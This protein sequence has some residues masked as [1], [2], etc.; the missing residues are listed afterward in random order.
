MAR[1]EKRRRERFAELKRL[2]NG[3]LPY[4][5]REYLLSRSELGFYLA[6]KTA[7][8][9]RFMIVPKVRLADIVNCSDADWN[10][11]HGDL[12]GRRHLDFVLCNRRTSKFALCVELDERTHDNRRRQDR[13]MFLNRALT[14]VG[15][16]I[17]RFRVRDHYHPEA[18]AE[19]IRLA[20]REE[21]GW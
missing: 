5:S 16:R 17:I 6:L 4:F 10:I 8:G 9:H 21:D 19:A 3:P 11:G 18:I 13:D 1:D 20:V 15:V 2:G 12:L 7:V 14:T